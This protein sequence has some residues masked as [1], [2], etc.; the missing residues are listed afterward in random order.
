[1]CMEKG[2]RLSLSKQR[3][4]TQLLTIGSIR[5]N[6]KDLGGNDTNYRCHYHLWEH[7]ES[8]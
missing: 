2:R 4:F 7:N 8:L 3:K 6:E 5:N 1:M